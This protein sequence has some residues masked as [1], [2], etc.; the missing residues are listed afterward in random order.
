MGLL[1][2]MGPGGFRR[3]GRRRGLIIGAAVGATVANRRN[4]ASQDPST[5]GVSSVT[6][7]DMQLSELEKL[8]DLKSKGV[9][10]DEEFEAKKKDILSQ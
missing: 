7:T 6:H 5:D 3:R 2:P 1:G 10:T 9:L 4:T 8:G